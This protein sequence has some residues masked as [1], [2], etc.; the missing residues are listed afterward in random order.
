VSVKLP[1]LNCSLLSFSFRPS[2]RWLLP[3]LAVGAP[4]C[5]ASGVEATPPAAG[6]AAGG[7]GG[8]EAGAAMGFAPAFNSFT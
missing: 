2:D 1:V 5:R 3:A 8:K 4:D 6:A 7:G